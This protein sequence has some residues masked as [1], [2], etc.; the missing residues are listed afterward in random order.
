MFSSG[1]QE[2]LANRQPKFSNFF[3][4]N[5]WHERLAVRGPNFQRKRTKFRFTVHLFAPYR[6]SKCQRFY[7]NL[8]CPGTTSIDVFSHSLDKEVTW[9]AHQYRRS[10]ELLDDWRIQ[11]QPGIYLYPNGRWLIIG[12]KILT[13]KVIFSSAWRNDIRRKV[14]GIESSSAWAEHDNIWNLDLRPLL[15]HHP[16]C[17]GRSFRLWIKF[18]DGVKGIEGYWGSHYFYIAWRCR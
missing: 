17:T 5:G 3:L 12:W 2:L 1:H 6:N 13:T 14:L 9:T 8:Y 4:E 7:C 16:R 10:S 15:A 11:G 18:S